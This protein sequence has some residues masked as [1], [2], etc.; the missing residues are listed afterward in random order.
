MLEGALVT[1]A[2]AAACKVST[3]AISMLVDRV[4]QRVTMDSLNR[5]SVWG[6]RPGMG[7]VDRLIKLLLMDVMPMVSNMVVS[8]LGLV[9]MGVAIIGLAMPGIASVEDTMIAV[10]VALAA[11]DEHALV[12]EGHTPG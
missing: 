8:M 4:I 10:V 7:I 6:L 2:A 9:L 11:L 5:I 12:V 1:M 3:V